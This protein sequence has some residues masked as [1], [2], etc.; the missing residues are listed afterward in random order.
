M[1]CLCIKE[2]RHLDSFVNETKRCVLI[3]TETAIVLASLA[4]VLRARHARLSR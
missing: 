4:V 1:A 2:R 3:L